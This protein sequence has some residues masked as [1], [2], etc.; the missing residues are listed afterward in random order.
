M[1]GETPNNLLKRYRLKIAASM[2]QKNKLRA[3]DVYYKVGFKHSNYF[4]NCFTKEFGVPPTQYSLEFSKLRE[5]II[6]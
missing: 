5:E 6:Q 1:T 4:I 3:S 2:L